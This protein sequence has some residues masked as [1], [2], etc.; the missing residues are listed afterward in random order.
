MPGRARAHACTRTHAHTGRIANR[1]VAN[2]TTS[3][4]DENDVETASIEK[5]MDMIIG[6]AHTDVTLRLRQKR[7]EGVDEKDM[8]FS[9]NVTREPIEVR[10]GHEYYR[11]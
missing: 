10:S 9:A 5:V 6:P 2:E 4:V 3:Q 1:H 7:I 8:E 11:S